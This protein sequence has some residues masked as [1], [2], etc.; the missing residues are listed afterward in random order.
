MLS[1]DTG[2]AFAKPEDIIHKLQIYDP[3]TQRN[4]LLVNWA[5]VFTPTSTKNKIIY[6]TNLEPPHPNNNLKCVTKTPIQQAK[7]C[8]KGQNTRTYNGT[9]LKMGCAISEGIRKAKSP[10]RATR[11]KIKKYTEAGCK[12]KLILLDPLVGSVLMYGLH[13]TPLRRTQIV[14]LQ[15]FYS[16]V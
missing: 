6:T 2:I 1:G 11:N 5:Q 15:S 14:K 8:N 12:L 10:W 13:I 16:C 4:R 9:S 7:M 3:V